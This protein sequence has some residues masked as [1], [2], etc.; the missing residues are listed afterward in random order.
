[1]A[2]WVF[3]DLSIAFETLDYSILL[4]KQ[5]PLGLILGPLLYLI[6]MNDIQNA[7][8]TLHVI[9]FADD[10]NLPSTL[11]S[12]DVNIDNNCNRMQL[13]DNINKELNIYIGV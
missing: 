2:Y 10:P 8:K 3:L 4:Y 9:L 7:S 5:N 6:Y 1:M 11:C 12:C 13:S